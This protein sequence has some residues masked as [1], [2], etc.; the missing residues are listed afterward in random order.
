MIGNGLKITSTH[1]NNMTYIIWIILGLIAA[2]GIYWLVDW[3]QH[4]PDGE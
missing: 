4:H 1:G 2:L 3:E